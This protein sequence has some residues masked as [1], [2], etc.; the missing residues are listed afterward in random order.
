MQPPGN[1]NW[2][3]I[4]PN[5][6]AYGKKGMTALIITKSWSILLFATKHQL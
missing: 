4:Y 3:L 2:H 5:F 1:T 6:S